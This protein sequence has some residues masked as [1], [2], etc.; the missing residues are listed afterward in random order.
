MAGGARAKISTWLSKPNQSWISKVTIR[1]LCKCC[2]ELTVPFLRRAHLTKSLLLSFGQRLE[3]DGMKTDSMRLDL[4]SLIHATFK[5]S[6]VLQAS[7]PQQCVYV[8][9]CRTTFCSPSTCQHPRYQLE[10]SRYAKHVHIELRVPNRV[11]LPCFSDPNFFSIPAVFF[12]ISLGTAVTPRRNEEQR[13]CKNCG[14]K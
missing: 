4:S 9:S 6:N 5:I 11:L 8:C 1:V 10:S 14:S 7:I 12:S 2:Y 3:D 13:L